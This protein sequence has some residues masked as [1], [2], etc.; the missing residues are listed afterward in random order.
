MGLTTC[1]PMPLN[2]LLQFWVDYSTIK[3]IQLYKVM[4]KLSHIYIRSRYRYK[5]LT[6]VHHDKWLTKFKNNNKTKKTSF[7]L[8]I[9][10]FEVILVISAGYQL[11]S[12]RIIRK[13]TIKGQE[14]P[15]N[16][17]L[18]FMGALLKERKLYSVKHPKT[19]FY[20]VQVRYSQY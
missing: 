13:D 9:R 3:F 5:L 8:C 14:V 20:C 10:S 19:F 16:I 17:W 6:T 4:F 7:R 12:A 11:P 2:Y 18:L 1:E 15:F